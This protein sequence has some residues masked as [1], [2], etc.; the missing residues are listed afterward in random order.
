[1]IVPRLEIYLDAQKNL[2]IAKVECEGEKSRLIFDVGL[3]E[4][5]SAEL[6]AA[7]AKFGGTIFN[8]LNIWHN[9]AFEGWGIPSAKELSQ[10]D[11]YEIAQRLIGKSV[12]DRTAM[13][14]S[15]IDLLLRQEASRNDDA[16]R[17]Y[18]DAWPAIRERLESY[19]V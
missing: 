4:L 9:A 8:L 18:A 12:A 5:K 16:K 13:H 3:D 7:S 11:D 2:C 19:S 6:G 17:F 10:S 15:S 14:V 1:M